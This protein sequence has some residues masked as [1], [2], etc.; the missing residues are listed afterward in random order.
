MPLRPRLAILLLFTPIIA[1]ADDL[2]TPTFKYAPDWLQAIGSELSLLDAAPRFQHNDRRALRELIHAAA[3][4][5]AAFRRLADLDDDL[6]GRLVADLDRYDQTLLPVLDDA[7]HLDVLK[8]AEFFGVRRPEA[9]LLVLRGEVLAE[10]IPLIRERA[11]RLA[12]EAFTKPAEAP[13]VLRALADAAVESDTPRV[14]AA[15]AARLPKDDADADAALASAIARGIARGDVGARELANLDRKLDA[16]VLARAL[17]VALNSAV[18]DTEQLNVL[19]AI[20]RTQALAN[21][22]GDDPLLTSVD[23]LAIGRTAADARATSRPATASANLRISTAA[24]AIT[25]NAGRTPDPDL[26]QLFRARPEALV[27]ALAPALA[28]DDK[29]ARLAALSTLRAFGQPSPAQLKPRLTA[30]LADADHDVRWLA[31]ECLGDERSLAVARVQDILADCR[32]DSPTLR[33]TAARQLHGLKLFPEVVT[34]GLLRA[35]AARDMAAR[36]GFLRAIERAYAVAGADPLLALQS[37]AADP[38]PVTRA[39][40]R[41][42]LRG[43]DA[44][45]AKPD[46]RESTPTPPT[47]KGPP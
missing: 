17:R 35:V 46:T 29:T 40:A 44:T 18:T 30:L 10:S 5:P 2:G 23:A 31:A 8:L 7:Q 9:V 26:I 4:S 36:E 41:A 20:A 6:R 27:D 16:V 1:S 43:L 34:A 22:P 21:L 13:R 19:A 24:L 37:A 14:A 15:A 42:A 33:E 11:R 39:C 28:A 25:V 12:D 45:T 38:D 47:K 32:A 3:T